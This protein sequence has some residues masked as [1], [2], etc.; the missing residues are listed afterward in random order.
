MF[1]CSRE[2]AHREQRSVIF[3]WK[4]PGYLMWTGLFLCCCFWPSATL[5]CAIKCDGVLSN[6]ATQKSDISFGRSSKA[7]FLLKTI[8]FFFFFAREM[9]TN[10]HIVGRSRP[11]FL[12][13]KQ[14]N[15]SRLEGK[16]PP[17]HALLSFRC[18]ISNV[19]PCTHTFNLSF[20]KPV[21]ESNSPTHT[22]PTRRKLA[23]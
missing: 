6:A 21:Q 2:A 15:I 11:G 19:L 16:I 3:V 5:L 1:T 23:D 7:R 20:I 10:K 13:S 9:K 17:R 12:T 22:A 14:V 4:R 18:N 8:L